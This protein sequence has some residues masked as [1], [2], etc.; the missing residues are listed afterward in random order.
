MTVLSCPCCP[1]DCLIGLGDLLAKF[2]ATGG[3]YVQADGVITGD[4]AL[5]LLVE[6]SDSDD[7]VRATVRA[8][9]LSA[10]GSFRLEAGRID[11]DT[12]V[13]IDVTVASSEVSFQLGYRRGGG[14]TLVNEQGSQ[15]MTSNKKK[16][17]SSTTQR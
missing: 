10:S 3:S 17:R 1:R 11:D 14:E 2:D 6:A 4:G 9:L 8:T 13:F 5:V 12:L 7:S 16:S 15:A